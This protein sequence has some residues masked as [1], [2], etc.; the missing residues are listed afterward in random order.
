MVQIS[1]ALIRKRAEHNEGL[2][3][4]LEEISL[5]QSDI[6][7]IEHID[8][9]CRDLKILYLQ[10]NL[11]DRIENVSKLKQLEYLN[12]ALNNIQKVENL[13]KC[14]NLNKLDLTVNFIAE[15]TSIESLRCNEFLHEMY[16][17]GNPAAKFEH[18]RDFVVG[19]L[20]QLQRL[21][22]IDITNTERLDATQNLEEIRKSIVWQQ[23]DYFIKE[24]K[25][26]EGKGGRWY[27]DIGA[28]E[29]PQATIEEIGKENEEGDDVKK[30]KNNK[31]DFWNTPVENTPDT[32][33]Q[34]HAKLEEERL[35]REAAQSNVRTNKVPKRETVLEREGKRLN[36]N[37]GKWPFLL[38]DSS[39]SREITLEVSVPKY[40][41]T[42][43][44]DM[45][46]QP[47]YIKIVAEGRTFQ[48]TLP[49]EVCPDT[50]SCQRSQMTGKLKITMPTLNQQWQSTKSV[51]KPSFRDENS[52]FLKEKQKKNDENNF[53][54]FDDK[55]SDLDFSKIVKSDGS[56]GAPMV[57]KTKPVVKVKQVPVGFEDD[58]DVPPLM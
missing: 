31:D 58:P 52:K 4:S 7:K 49:V 19:T 25:K 43:N 1:E 50:S 14:E 51:S 3:F 40:L 45:D 11:I 15:L 38:D 24:R 41:S 30:P 36:L 20:P 39:D 37:Q 8:K 6:E 47:T 18:Y 23:E 32:R 57:T 33:K 48:L 56:K 22:G 21:D 29:S 5:H 2:I 34:I 35:E 13:E 9:W 44:I 10:S 12:L 55:K 28:E 27:T 16:M 46:V 17:T 53:L 54:E 42:H 26:K